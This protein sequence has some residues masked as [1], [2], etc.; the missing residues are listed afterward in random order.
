[1]LDRLDY[2]FYP[3]GN[4]Y[5][6]S[7]FLDDCPDFPGY[8]KSRSLCWASRCNATDAPPACFNGTKLCQHGPAECEANLALLARQK[9]AAEQ[10]AE[11]AAAA[12]QSVILSFNRFFE[13]ARARCGTQIL[14][15]MR[16]AQLNAMH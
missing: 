15:A 16:S 12:E 4:A 2:N 13:G 9:V 1:M 8:G 11:Q 5:F 6:N 3:W 7:S 14:S 10:H